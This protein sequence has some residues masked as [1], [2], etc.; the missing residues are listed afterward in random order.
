M[1]KQEKI[2]AYT[3]IVISPYNKYFM[4]KNKSIYF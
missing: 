3:I 1:K 2:S 4:D